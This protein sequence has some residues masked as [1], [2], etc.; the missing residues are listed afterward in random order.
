MTIFNHGAENSDNSG[1][2]SAIK[3]NR[4]KAATAAVTDTSIT[5]IA[6]ATA[7]T[8]LTT[9]TT[10]REMPTATAAIIPSG[11]LKAIILTNTGTERM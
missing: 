7:T 11:L 4:N 6:T 5:E 1:M 3:K 9:L 10:L 8:T 2:R